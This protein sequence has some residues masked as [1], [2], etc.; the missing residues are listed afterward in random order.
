MVS[1]FSLAFERL[2]LVDPT[3]KYPLV[4]LKLSF[5]SLS[6]EPSLLSVS[7]FTTRLR[8]SLTLIPL[9]GDYRVLRIHY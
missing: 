5:C 3:E 8:D 9:T 2:F 6:G 1:T 7:R 4:H